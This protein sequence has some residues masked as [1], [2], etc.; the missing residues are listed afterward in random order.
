MWA[1][2]IA[3]MSAMMQQRSQAKLNRRK[4]EDEALAS[5]PSWRYR[6]RL[7]HGAYI[8]GVIMII[9]GGATVFMTSQIGVEL[10][11]GGVAL[12]S[13]IITAY[14]TSATY[15]DVRI[16]NHNP[17]IRFGETEDE[18]GPGADG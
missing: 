17:R 10:I 14:T 2:L 15:E 12:L 16:W 8:I 11:I 18:Y 5:G 1:S 6:R 13:I 4:A 7:I 9:A 3:T